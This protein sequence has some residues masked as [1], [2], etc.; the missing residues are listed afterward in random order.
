MSD[1]TK[2][3]VGGGLHV[4]PWAGTAQ[5]FDTYLSSLA[6]LDKM[7]LHASPDILAMADEWEEEQEDMEIEHPLLKK[8]GDVGMVYVKGSLIE[9]CC[10]WWEMRWGGM[11][12]YEDI[13]NACIAALNAG[14]KVIVIVYNTSGG[15]VTGIGAFTDFLK[16]TVAKLVPVYGYTDTLCCSAGVWAA[17]TSGNFYA[18]QHA[19]LGSIGVIKM[20]YE[21]TEMDKMDG[22]KRRVFKSNPGK[23]AGNPYEKLSSLGS[24]MLDVEVTQAGSR[25]NQHIATSMPLDLAYV[26]STLATGEVWY[27]DVALAKKLVNKNITLD[28]LVIDLQKKVSQNSQRQAQTPFT[29]QLKLAA[30]HDLPETSDMAKLHLNAETAAALAAASAQLQAGGEGEPATDPVENEPAEPET[31][32]PSEVKAQADQADLG[33]LASSVTTLTAQLVAAST[34]LA[35]L[36]LAHETLKSQMS[37]AEASEAGLKAIAV[38]AIQWSFVAAGGQAPSGDALLALS[39][40]L[41]VKQHTDAKALLAKKFG[42]GGQHAATGGDEEADAQTDKAAAELER[43][44]LLPLSRIGR[45]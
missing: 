36:K 43:A 10:G 22:V 24:D 7:V 31:P 25:F 5:G 6:K 17:V 37:L 12:G 20:V 19:L 16:G 27:G 32:A 41:L 13:R 18:S 28:Q 33:V 30:S 42:K 38:E 34:E 15:M 3:T 11:C 29:Q 40:S 8:V 26:Q 9:G 14:C 2:A 21:I 44:V 1:I 45:H 39:P 23:G 35:T 4:I